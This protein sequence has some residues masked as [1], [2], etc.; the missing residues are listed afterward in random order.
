MSNRAIPDLKNRRQAETPEHLPDPT[1][2][3]FLVTT[4][5]RLVLNFSL[6]LFCHC[7]VIINNQ[8]D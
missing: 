3:T 4:T 7:Q 6:I 2:S 1:S 5:S 8:L